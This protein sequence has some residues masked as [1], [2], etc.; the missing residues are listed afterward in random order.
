MIRMA[1]F[2]VALFAALPLVGSIFID[3]LG[4]DPSLLWG[5]GLLVPAFLSFAVFEI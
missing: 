2:S 5:V 1:G 4:L 3:A